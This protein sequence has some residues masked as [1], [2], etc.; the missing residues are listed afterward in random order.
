MF[1]Y[2]VPVLLCYL[3]FAFKYIF[4]GPRLKQECKEKPSSGGEEG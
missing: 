2:A 1:R 3:F 4:G